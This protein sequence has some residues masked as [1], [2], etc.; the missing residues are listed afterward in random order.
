MN[1]QIVALFSFIIYLAFFGWLG[2]KRG[3]TR[4]LIVFLTALL[5]WLILQQRG[6][7]VVSMA[8]LVGAGIEF[9]LAGGFSGSEEEA[10]AAIINAERLVPADSE[11]IFLYLLWV[12]AVVIVYAGTTWLVSKSKSNGWA[13]LLGVLNAFFFAIVFVPGMA[14]LFAQ[15]GTLAQP[16]NQF[17]LVGM[18]GRGL[19][20]V[21]DGI[22]AMWGLIAPLGSMGILV[23]VTGILVLAALSI[24]G[25]RA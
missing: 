2:Y 8:N 4:E 1:A 18:L 11:T 20:L 17:D 6:D 5:G 19:E 10:F 12:I 22:V 14:A 15:D 25:A 21:R 9:T 24:R 3:V 16:E 23:V 13:V 7:T